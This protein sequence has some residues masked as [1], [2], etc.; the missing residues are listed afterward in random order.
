MNKNVG[1]DYSINSPALTI[2]DNNDFY[3]Y[4]FAE[5]L[6]KTIPF[7]DGFIT[8]K[9]EKNGNNIIDASLVAKDILKILQNH[10]VINVN[11][12][13]YSYQSSSK[14]IFQIAENTGILKYFLLQAGIKINIIQP[15]T[16]KQKAGGGGFKKFDMLQAFLKQENLKDNLFHQNCKKYENELYKYN[17][18]KTMII[19]VKSPYSDI[20]DSYYL[21]VI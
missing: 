16:V 14:A 10:N 2:K 20:V 7:K 12:E 13:G 9:L 11:L 4:C 21:S 15:S 18:D 3:F 8:K 6:P 5:K 17:Q 1:I 19:G